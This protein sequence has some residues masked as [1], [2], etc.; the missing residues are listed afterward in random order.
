MK[1]SF[2]NLATVLFKLIPFT[3]FSLFS[4][5]LEA[6]TI[7]INAVNTINATCSN[8]AS[9]SVNATEALPVTSLFYSLT[10]STTQTNSSGNFTNLE[11]G[12][13]Y[14]KVFNLANDSAIQSNI[15]VTTSYTAPVIQRVDTIAPYCD[16]DVN[17]K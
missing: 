6:G 14:L 1:K 7:T 8:N 5:H 16:K 11:A 3:T 4:F 13:Y 12:T 17:G 10:G 15:I 2:T 9:I